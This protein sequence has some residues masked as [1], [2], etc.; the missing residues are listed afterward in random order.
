MYAGI[1]GG[2]IS[3][4]Y[5]ALELSK[6]HKVVLFDERDYL[7]GRILTKNHLELGAARFNDTH[8]L[9][10]K[11][12]KQ[13]NLTPISIPQNQDYILYNDSPNTYKNI[14]KAF[15]SCIQN[16]INETPINEKLREITFYE[17]CKNKIGS[18]E[19]DLLLSVFGYYTEFKVLNAYDAI[20]TF[21]NDFV[22]K[23]YYILKEGL[24][25]LCNRMK[26]EIIKNGSL[27]YINEKVIKVSSNHITTH[28]QKIRVDNIIF[29]TKARQLNEFSILKPIHKY[30]NALH[31][32]PLI[33]IYAKYK[34]VW[35]ND[36]N[37][38]TTNNVLRQ[39]IP[40]DKEN[41]IIM[42]SYTDGE[43]TKPFIHILKNEV[44]L[45]KF[46]SK[47]LSLL[48]PNK[49]IEE[50]EYI[51]PYSWVVGTHSWKVHTN[52][53]EIYNKVL[54]PI[55]NIYICGEAYCKKQAW[56]E[57]ALSMANDVIINID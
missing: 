28:K 27:I 39:I 45:R 20:H 26:K 38:T 43:D 55:D 2:G 54:N 5:C 22:S 36:L 1:I 40:I 10:L 52:S 48:F 14:N 47:Q 16:I 56:I 9:L 12:I 42:I 49:H 35:F 53:E 6:K 34:N 17:H 33:R 30:L 8:I 25:E 3:G 11:L 24:S 23:Q 7:G 4:L 57:G 15:D 32:A 18:L 13:F 29:C 21:K 51:I 37:R 50:P 46:I 19:S 44:K 31:E 41:G